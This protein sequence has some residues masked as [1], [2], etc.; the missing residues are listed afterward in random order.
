MQP[1]KI[2]IAL[3]DCF[4]LGDTDVESV[5]DRWQALL[6]QQ[7][8]WLRN[9]ADRI[10]KKSDKLGN[11]DGNIIA[12]LILRDRGFVR[13]CQRYDLVIENRLVATRPP[14]RP[15]TTASQWSHPDIQSIG[16][17]ADWLCISQR[18]LDWLTAP[19]G[20]QHYHYRWLEKIDGSA[21]L[22]EV[23]KHRLK[24]VQRQILKE[25][26]SFIPPHEAAHGFSRGR[27]VRTFAEPHVGNH[28]VLRVDLQDFFLSIRK[29][30]IKNLFASVGYPHSVAGVFASL[31]TNIAPAEIPGC[32]V[33]QRRSPA[34]CIPHSRPHLPQ[35]APT[36]PALANLAAFRLDC[37]LFGLANACGVS[38]TRYADDL[39]FSGGTELTRNAKRFL[40]HVY[41]TILEEGFRVHFRKSRVMR[42]GTRQHLAGLT[43]NQHI[44]INRR[45]YDRVKAI[46]HNC[47]RTGPASQ[48]RDDHPDFESHLRGKLTFFSM[49]NPRRTKKLWQL[50][51]R[52]QWSSDQS[53]SRST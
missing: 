45:D 39:A 29:T 37:R 8:R 21:R 10:S 26:L 43:V 41:A 35:G 15:S 32:P 25:L 30:R 53:V 52:I 46:L 19:Y 1:S 18:I 6:G 44:N 16:R 9:L 31:C 27:S 24:Q 40:N 2:A 22:I 12:D 23:P 49:V 17:L 14:M 34:G 13:A 3:A 20:N 48:N 7:L 51:D 4:L 47:V 28:V 36:S 38:Y 42:E 33:T 11:V 5:T 50:F